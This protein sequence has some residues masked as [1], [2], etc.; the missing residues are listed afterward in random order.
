MPSTLFHS[1]GESPETHIE[2]TLYHEPA[3]S[4]RARYES[5]PLD[6]FLAFEASHS[7]GDYV[8]V[9]EVSDH[10]RIITAPGYS[11]GY[12]QTV[13]G[14]TAA[15]TLSPVLDTIPNSE[16]ALSNP[17]VDFFIEHDL[18]H[19][20]PISTLFD[21]VS[22]LPPATVLEISNGELVRF[23]CYAGRGSLQ[24]TDFSQ[25]FDHTIQ[26][27]GEG[28]NGKIT[29][30]YSGG[31]DSTALYLALADAVGESRIDPVS[32]DLGA[33]SNS[34]YRA[35]DVGKRFGISPRVVDVGYPPTDQTVIE[36]IEERLTE[37]FLNP[38]NPHWAFATASSG[39]VVL[40]GQNMD[41][42]LTVD[43]HRPQASYQTH[44]FVTHT[45]SDVVTEWA[46][47]VQHTDWYHRSRLLRHIYATL[48]DVLGSDF[49]GDPSKAGLFRGLLGTTLP[50]IVPSESE[51]INNEIDRLA[52]LLDSGPDQ[53]DRKI[54][55]YLTYEH[56]ASKSIQ[57]FSLDT[58]FHLPAMWGPLM[59]YG[60]KKPRKIRDAVS[61]KREIFSYIRSKTGSDYRTI[62]FE[63]KA[64]LQTMY[65][66]RDDERSA[67]I[68]ELL[69]R[70]Q[71]HLSPDQSILIQK[72][73]AISDS[74]ATQY[75]EIQSSINELSWGQ[76]KTGHRILNVEQI[77]SEQL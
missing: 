19:Q 24:S 20:L 6:Q 45:I 23:D 76:L 74:L 53:W 70:N 37:D 41:A 10:T 33:H 39:D 31:A 8:F 48:P 54:V 9:D 1:S 40:S 30:M 55:N 61:P 77:L 52:A 35:V 49:E 50:N 18:S 16:L 36:S 65:Q 58:H 29:L 59:T 13:S 42:M 3:D 73:P 72:C 27:I 21:G 32:F 4:I 66:E 12:V 2:G 7:I 38:M 34:S 60:I 22:R 67:V 43:M 68:S 51:A 56:N 69:L 71:D 14:V 26:E 75:H 57:T 44:L 62:A 17:H 28:V 15:R 11:G 64:E 63:S 5:D 46:Q 47:N 25:V